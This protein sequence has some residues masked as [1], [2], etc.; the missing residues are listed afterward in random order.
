M[1]DLRYFEY[2]DEEIAYLSARDPKMAEAIAAI[3]P[4]QRE[5]YP[6][7]FSAL[8]NSIVG[9]QISTK[10]HATV[11][12][13]ML[14]AFGDITPEVMVACSDEELQRVG[15]TFRKAGYI[16]GAAQRVLA[17]EVDL[18]ALATLPDDEVCRELSS[19]PGV[20]TWTAEML[21]TFSMQRPD[22]MSYGDLGIQRGLR[23]LHHHRRIT[24]ELFAKYSRR[25]S[26][27]GT[28]A[29]LY[30]WEIAAGAIPDMRDWAPKAKARK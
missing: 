2:G 29:S 28:V 12:S 24:P 7:L 8:V 16:K 27:Y 6:D 15:I 19:L 26:P 23:M 14:E 13:R 1:A 17:G 22:I 25:Y 10:A 20:G 30:L 4:L 5:V 11:W 18:A 21:M 3:G 9:Q